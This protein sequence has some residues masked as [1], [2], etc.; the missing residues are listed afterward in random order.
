M[1]KVEAIRQKVSRKI[2]PIFNNIDALHVSCLNATPLLS[3]S[4][5]K[6]CVGMNMKMPRNSSLINGTYGIKKL[7]SH[8][9]EEVAVCGFD[10]EKERMIINHTPQG[11][12]PEF[13]SSI[14][15]R[16]RLG[17]SDFRIEMMQAMIEI[18]KKLHLKEV[19]GFPIK[20]YFLGDKEIY[21]KKIKVKNKIFELFNF[22]LI[23]S[24]LPNESYYSLTL[25]SPV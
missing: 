13:F 25:N 9:G 23:G 15:A 7:D 22:S 10:I 4:S 11:N 24:E 2:L 5:L 20:P 12:R 16:H 17:R 8:T 1:S 18:A 6:M 3:D 19:V 14:Q 21:S